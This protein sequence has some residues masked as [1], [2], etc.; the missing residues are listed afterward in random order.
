MMLVEDANWSQGSNL[1]MLKHPRKLQFFTLFET[2]PPPPQLS[3]MGTSSFW[4]VMIKGIGLLLCKP[5]EWSSHTACLCALQSLLLHPHVYSLAAHSFWTSAFELSAHSAIMLTVDD[6]VREREYRG[7]LWNA[8]C[9]WLT[10]VWQ[11]LV[12]NEAKHSLKKKNYNLDACETLLTLT[13][14]DMG[15]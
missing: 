12:L 13:H 1:T 10:L 8:D 2:T 7:G 4:P 15:W 11:D 6:G 14:R 5:W 3:R 9:P